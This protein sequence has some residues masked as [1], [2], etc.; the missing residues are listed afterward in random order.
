MGAVNS[1]SGGIYF[2]DAPGRTRKTFLISLLFTLNEVALVFASSGI[3]VTLL[4]GRKTAHSSLKLPQNIQSKET[5]DCNIT[6]N[7]TMAKI[8]QVCKLIV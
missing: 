8:L 7:S 6:K 2:L 3:A 5:P 4:E 1:G